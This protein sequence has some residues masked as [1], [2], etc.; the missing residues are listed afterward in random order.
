MS[1]K[2]YFIPSF[3]SKNNNPHHT[4]IY[5]CL[6]HLLSPSSYQ[7][8]IAGIILD[9]VAVESLSDCWLYIYLCY[10]IVG[11]RLLLVETHFYLQQCRSWNIE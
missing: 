9:L 2:I 8:P 5:Y 3:S 1:I 11:L 4:S 10:S 7:I 6:A